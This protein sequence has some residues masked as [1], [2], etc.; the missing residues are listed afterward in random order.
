[1]RRAAHRAIAPSVSD[2][3][4]SFETIASGIETGASTSA[5][6]AALRAAGARCEREGLA[7]VRQAVEAWERVWPRLG[8][9]PEFRTAVVREARLWAKKLA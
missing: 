7:N 9:Q 2:V 3:S 8:A 5:V 1:M 6:V 4:A